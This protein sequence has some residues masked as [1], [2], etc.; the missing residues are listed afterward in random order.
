MSNLQRPIVT[1]V[2]QLCATNFRGL[3]GERA[4]DTDADVVLLQGPNGNGKSSFIEA[5]LLVLTGSA[6][7]RREPGEALFSRIGLG[8][9]PGPAPEFQLVAYAEGLLA[10]TARHRVDLTI[11]AG[12]RLGEQSFSH[13]IRV[14]SGEE[15]RWYHD[16]PQAGLAALF[17]ERPK[18]RSRLTA[19]FQDDVE[20]LFDDASRGETLLN[21]VEPVPPSIDAARHVLEAEADA[22]DQEAAALLGEPVEAQALSEARADF[23]AWTPTLRSILDAVAPSTGGWPTCP[24]DDDLA[25]WRDYATDVLTRARPKTPSAERLPT[26]FGELLRSRLPGWLNAAEQE[27]RRQA[28]PEESRRLEDELAATRARLKDNEQK[29]PDLEVDLTAFAAD[30]DERSAGAV[31]LERV[32]FSL[33]AGASRWH[34][35][36][37]TRAGVFADLAR[38]LQALNLPALKLASE[39]LNTWVADREAALAERTALRKRVDDLAKR[40]WSLTPPSVHLETLRDASRRVADLDTSRWLKAHNLLLRE[41]DAP[42]RE[43]RSSHLRHLAGRVRRFATDVANLRESTGDVLERLGTALTMV[44]GRFNLGPGSLPIRIEPGEVLVEDDAE[45]SSAM[46]TR[47]QTKLTFNDGRGL[48]H[49]SSGQRSQVAVAFMTA[50]NLLVRN[51]EGSI[52]DELPHRVLLLDD[53]ATSYDLSN[54]V[55]ETLIWRQ[56]AYTRNP[57]KKRQIFISSHHEDLTNQLVDLLAPPHGYS[58][59]VL[60]FHDW[61]P[62]NGPA[63]REMRV[64][65]APRLPATASECEPLRRDLEQVLLGRTKP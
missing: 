51:S 4:I 10:G 19:F 8:E 15:S 58:M 28:S 46:R 42:A 49:F 65:P 40:L 6:L 44:A 64:G 63:I 16:D 31:S 30:R 48:G 22:L 54:L 12:A 34:A 47:R 25:A 50:Q 57:K 5:L 24:A 45:G 43:R 26:E 3:V 11:K 55:V 1:R 52:P 23:A 38:E 2:R 20:R 37:A 61:T 33:S 9:P 62:D 17:S 29:Y 27:A 13:T 56:L 41:E 39:A 35:A 36:A 32:L 14:D 53:V 60:N 59:R 7:E 18:L 21:V